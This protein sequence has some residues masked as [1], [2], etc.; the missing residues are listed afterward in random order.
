MGEMARKISK[1]DHDELL[2]I[3]NIAYA[4]EWL[5]YYQYWL[6]AQVA[7]GPH[8]SNIVD[9]F[10]EHAAQ[11]LKHAQMLS[12]RI[13]ELGGV[14]ILSPSKWESVALCHYEEPANPQI[15]ELLKQNLISERCAIA[16]YEKICE[17]TFGKDYETHR[18]SA[19]ILHEELEHE[20]EISDFQDDIASELEIWCQND[21]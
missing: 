3:L 10:M 13:I 9:E 14:P 5:A 18:I 20:Q 17:M 7:L 2:K 16:R 21:K 1:V 15:T 19:K 6:G 11:E 12:D 4:E 8:R